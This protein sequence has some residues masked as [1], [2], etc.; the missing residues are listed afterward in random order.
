MG[1]GVRLE[2]LTTLGLGLMLPS[3]PC[4]LAA[5]VT[6]LSVSMLVARRP[7]SAAAPR[8]TRDEGAMTCLGAGG[9]DSAVGWYSVMGSKRCETL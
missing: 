3:V 4:A 7:R 8:L 9:G 1:L 5:L 6:S 2:L